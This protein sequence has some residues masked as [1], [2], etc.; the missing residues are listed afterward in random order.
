MSKETLMKDIIMA[1]NKLQQPTSPFRKE[2][3]GT[4]I[5]YMKELAPMSIDELMVFK[6]GLEH[7]VKTIE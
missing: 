1:I 3:D 2:F 6:M 5:S 4:L 7:L